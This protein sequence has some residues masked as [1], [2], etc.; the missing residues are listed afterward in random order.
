MSIYK[1][2][3]RIDHFG[4]PTWFEE[5]IVFAENFYDAVDKLTV[6]Y[7]A[8][9]ME[10]EELIGETVGNIYITAGWERYEHYIS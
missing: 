9:N 2:V 1:F 3:V 8:D 6:F 4:S 5:G 10:I 7:H